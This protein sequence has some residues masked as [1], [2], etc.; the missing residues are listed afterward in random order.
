MNNYLFVDI[1]TTGLDENEDDILEIAAYTVTDS[2]EPD[3]VFH[4]IMLHNSHVSNEEVRKMHTDNEL[5]SDC[6]TGESFDSIDTDFRDYMDGCFLDPSKKV[7]LAG[8]SIHFDKRFLLHD[9][10]WLEAYLHYRVLDIRSTLLLDPKGGDQI[11]L[12]Y[13]KDLHRA[14]PDC[15][16][17]IYTAKY[18]QC[19]LSAS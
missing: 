10:T 12:P 9:F 7:I 16:N 19:R 6:I 18:Y 8:S 17:A 5:I 4:R 3:R 13:R 11:L 14:T 15:L 2:F 1:E